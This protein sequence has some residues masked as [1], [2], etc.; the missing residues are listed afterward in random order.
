MRYTFF[1]ILFLQLCSA[2]NQ[3]IWEN[4]EK[5]NKNREEPHTLLIP[6]DNFEQAK[7]FNYFL[8]K[9]FQSL[10]GEWK[11]NY[12][13]SKSDKP[14]GFYSNSFDISSWESIKVPGNWEI[15]GFGTPYY[16]DEEYPFT[17]DPPHFKKIDNP[18]GCYKRAFIIP[19]SWN[20]KQIFI[21]FASVRP[22]LHLWINGRK[23]GF[24]KGSK[25]PSEFNITKYIT[26][27]ENLVSV[28]IP[29]WCDASYLEGQDT[30]RLSGIERDAFLYAKNNYHIYDI[31]IKP[32]LED[33]LKDG[34]LN[35]SFE[36]KNHQQTSQKAQLEIQILD[37]DQK[38]LVDTNIFVQT[39]NQLNDTIW[40]THYF[41]Q[42]NKWNAENPY[43]YTIRA[44]LKYKNQ[45]EL[46]SQDFGFRKVEIKGE[47]MLVNGV[48]IYI[49]GVNRCEFDP[50]VGRYASRKNMER[51]I[52]LMKQFN[53]NAV[54]S[55]HYPSD[56]YWYYLCDKYGLYV[57]DEA[58]IEAHGMQFHE[59][60]YAPITDNPKW[61]KAFLDRTHRLIETDKN[62][63]S[64]IIWSMGNE[65]GDGLNFKTL[66]R[67]IKS[68]DKSRPIQYQPAW[69][70]SH[71]DIVCPM[72]RNIDFLKKY[73]TEK[74]NKPLILCEYAHA[75]GNSVGNLQD[76]WDVIERYPM[77]QGGFIW[78]WI[79]Q[80]IYKEI[81]TIPVWAYGGD[82][83]DKHLNDSNFCANGL[84]QA[85][86]N[87]NPHIWEVKKVYE[88]IEFK[89][90]DLNKQLFEIENKYDFTNLSE[91]YF[92][93]DLMANGK[94]IKSGKLPNIDLEPK[95][96]I[97]INPNIKI[98]N[99]TPNT[100]YILTFY[101]RRRFEK[102][103]V[104]KNH[105]IAWQQF[106]LPL[107]KTKKKKQV[108]SDK[109]ILTE[110]ES[111]L[112]LS[113]NK[114]KLTLDRQTG[115][116]KS[117]QINK[118]EYFKSGPKPD[119]WRAP[120]D[121][122]LGNLMFSRC[123]LWNKFFDK[124]K[125]DD[126]KIKKEKDS[127]H[128]STIYS[129]KETGTQHIVAYTMNPS[130][131]ISVENIFT[132][133]LDSL[134]ELPRFGNE[135]L[136]KAEFENIQWYGRGAHESYW[137]RKTGAAVGIYRA[138]VWEQYHPYVRPQENGNKTDVRWLVLSDK[139]GN[140]LMFIGDT[141]LNINAQQFDKKLL[142]R[143]N[144]SAPRHGNEIKKGDV[145]SLNIDYQQM[146][147]GGDNTWGA[148]TH[149]QYTLPAKK[150]SYSYSII[151]INL[152][153]TSINDVFIKN[154]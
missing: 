32:E 135:M 78:D 106:K 86:G 130:G 76:Y 140:G 12:S 131:K 43:L 111:E 137:D 99:I 147:V 150:Y 91:F 33:N 44:C 124:I 30:W 136:L 47:Q 110:K 1:V 10:N 94:I 89:A 39:S 46:I 153:K 45:S 132:P 18:V 90:L 138:T 54:R 85:D 60:S 50:Y 17:P 119:F 20:N 77:L 129:H 62:H 36:T 120:T 34:I 96:R 53:I 95:R 6:Y 146:G 87:L 28:E 14:K 113:N 141:L 67:Y 57:V 26:K 19:D 116:I 128:I 2:C 15:Q 5:V 92:T 143:Y 115:L 35:V 69:Y 56:P 83:D 84:I 73:V 8:S 66:Y 151:P 41:N 68:K 13:K 123:K 80:T 152:N 21:H 145:I 142:E 127:Y 139:N 22:G 103:L 48:P 104:P 122:D 25:T 117:Y 58:N 70:N 75:M 59:E 23:V 51:D 61:E 27:G 118:L 63:A 82:F 88:N 114:F 97:E 93:W 109:L 11:F 102:Q 49:K 134:P 24:S 64:I 74:H 148:R 125:L 37:Q 149:K 101:A 154:Q 121:N 98:G 38:L 4:P 55:S 81:N 52:K 107:Y 108:Y 144:S 16:L 29:R 3:N 72:Y 65:A 71:T 7:E 9:S 126:I 79:D 112:I 133:H 40:F 105:L 100:E 31:N 42:P